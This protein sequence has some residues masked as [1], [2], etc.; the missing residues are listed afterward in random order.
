MHACDDHTRVM[1]VDDTEA[2]RFALGG[3]LEALRV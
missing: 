2:L 3:V 1:L